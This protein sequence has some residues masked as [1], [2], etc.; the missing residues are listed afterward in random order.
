MPQALVSLALVVAIIVA[1]MVS[2]L[3]GPADGSRLVE[4]EHEMKT[5]QELYNKLARA[6]ATLEAAEP[7]SAR[8]VEASRLLRE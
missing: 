5:Q 1:V 6:S 4:P 3:P 2:R 8:I 7:A